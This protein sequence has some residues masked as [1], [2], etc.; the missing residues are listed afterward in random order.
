MLKSIITK[1]RK[2]LVDKVTKAYAR[3]FKNFTKKMARNFRKEGVLQMPIM[4]D[5]FKFVVQGV[6]PDD[7]EK[8]FRERGFTVDLDFDEEIRGT[9]II[10]RRYYPD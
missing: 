10:S 6:L 1:N 4:Y 3:A 2:N 7:L 9:T 5:E 8:L